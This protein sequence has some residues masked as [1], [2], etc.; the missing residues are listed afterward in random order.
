MPHDVL[1]ITAGITLLSLLGILLGLRLGQRL[2]P[3]LDVLLA[4]GGSFILGSV[5]LHFNHLHITPFIGWTM[6][7]GVVIQMILE[8]LTGGVEHGHVHTHP[9]PS[10]YLLL[11][12]SFHATLESI[13]ISDLYGYASGLNP[14]TSAILWHRLPAAMIFGIMLH[15][16]PRWWR[17]LWATVFVLATPFGVW[18]GWQAPAHLLALIEGVALGSLLYIGGT[19]VYEQ[20]Q[21]HRLT[22][23]K[24]SG[25]IL[26][27]IL[28][29]LLHLW[30]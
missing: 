15:P 30:T 19:I 25:L 9:L 23:R 20:S 13:P 10:T 2:I 3:H 6:L 1:L 22:G 4:M 24:L 27:F 17:W 12:L 8:Q 11:G 16:L 5:L 14:I 21:H 28:A 7:L 18:L 29:A 26:G